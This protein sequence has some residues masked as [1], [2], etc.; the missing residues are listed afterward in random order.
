MHA[1]TVNTSKSADT[2]ADPQ[3]HTK[4]HTQTLHNDTVMH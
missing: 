1:R 3:T 4:L 2:V